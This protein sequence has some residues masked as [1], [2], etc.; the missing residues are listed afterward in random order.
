MAR[1]LTT[2][3][4]QIFDNFMDAYQNNTL[5]VKKYTSINTFKAGLIN[6]DTPKGLFDKIVQRMPLTSQLM[7][8]PGVLYTMPPT[9]K[10]HFKRL[11]AKVL[12]NM[13]IK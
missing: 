8:N 10:T 9:A 2:N 11:L 5:E 6:G 7:I 3:Q 4:Q 13:L 1:I 12:N